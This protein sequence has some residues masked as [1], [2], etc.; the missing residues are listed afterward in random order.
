MAQVIIALGSNLGDRLI[1][2]LQ[3]RQ[4][5]ESISLSPV[6]ASSIYE[7]EPVGN[8]ESPYYYNAVC[9]VQTHLVPR[10]LLLQLK[11]YE[12]RHGRDPDAPRWNDRTIDLDIIDYNRLVWTEENLNIP[13]PEYET[14]RFVLDPLQE[15]FPDWTDIRNNRPIE[16]MISEAPQ[17]AVFKC[18]VIW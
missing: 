2:L 16:Q 6:R 13:H 18:P 14:R 9:T 17:I 5:L 7:T 11:N 3:A 12:F 15:L 8:P 10:E 4:F 1:N